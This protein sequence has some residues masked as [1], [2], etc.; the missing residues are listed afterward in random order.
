M[1][2]DRLDS[3]L[4]RYI[5]ERGGQPGQQLPSIERLSGQLG[6]SAGKLREQL[7]V[8]RCLGLVEVKPK[9]GIRLTAYSFQPAVRSSLFY[10]LACH[11]ARFEQFSTLRQHLETAYWDEAVRSLTAADLAHLRALVA[12]ARAKLHG[13]PIRIPH[14]EHRAFHLTIFAR[15]DNPFVTGLLEVYWDAY[16]AIGLSMFSDYDYLQAV[17]DHHAEIAEA[18]ERREAER[19]RQ[20][21]VDHFNLLRNRQPLNGP[22]AAIASIG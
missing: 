13:R 20:V 8:A 3:A 5:V 16:E 21:L 17:W 22:E 9:L 10:A 11:Q 1:L 12:E 19:G 7:E 14:A 6:V 4:L 18:A 15:L 2:N